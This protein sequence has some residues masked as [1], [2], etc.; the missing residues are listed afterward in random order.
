LIVRSKNF[1]DGVV[2]SSNSV[3]ALNL[4]R[5]HAAT[6]EDD[7]KD[8]AQAVFVAASLLVERYPQA[9]GKLL[10]AV[11]WVTEG[12]KEVA[13]VGSPAE[14]A[15][16]LKPARTRFNPNKFVA[17]GEKPVIPLLEGKT[18]TEGKATI[19]VCQNRACR[20]PTVLPQQALAALEAKKTYPL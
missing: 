16:F 8:R 14:S 6:Y 10:H 12:A 5:L 19:Y 3:S 20:L 15:E 17:C 11:D 2:P 1:E 13:I 18:R 4:L 7:Y 9:V